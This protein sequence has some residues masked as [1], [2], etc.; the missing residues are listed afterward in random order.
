MIVGAERVKGQL[1]ADGSRFLATTTD[2]D[3]AALMCDG[4]PLG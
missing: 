3:L 4:A 2:A 1:D